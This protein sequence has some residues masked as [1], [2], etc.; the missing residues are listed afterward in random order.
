MAAAKV[1]GKASRVSAF[2][3][4]WAAAMREEG[5][6]G[7]DLAADLLGG[8]LPLGFAFAEA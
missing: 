3:V 4:M 2:V 7:R 5:V 6:D 1:T 8:K